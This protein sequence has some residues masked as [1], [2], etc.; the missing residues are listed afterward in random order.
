MSHIKIRTEYRRL[1]HEYYVIQTALGRSKPPRFE[2]AICAAMGHV[3][4]SPEQWVYGAGKVPD[5]LER[6]IEDQQKEEF[7]RWW[8]ENEAEELALWGLSPAR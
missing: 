8:T 4:A 2:F 3:P 5:D 1:R 7:H 6:E